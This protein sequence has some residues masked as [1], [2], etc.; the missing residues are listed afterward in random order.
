MRILRHARRC[1]LETRVYL[2]TCLRY[3]FTCLLVYLFTFYLFTWCVVSNGPGRASQETSFY[4]MSSVSV[5][6]ARTIIF[7]ACSSGCSQLLIFRWIFTL[8]ATALTL[9]GILIQLSTTLTLE[10]FRLISMRPAAFSGCEGLLPCQTTVT[11][12]AHCSLVCGPWPCL[13]NAGAPLGWASPAQPAFHFTV[14]FDT[15]S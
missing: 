7:K 10:K 9:S 6:F 2:F 14:L 5:V 12:P 13:P 3:L 4:G 1:R 8:L 15:E 11:D